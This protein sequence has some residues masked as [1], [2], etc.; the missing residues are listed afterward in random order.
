[1]LHSGLK[2]APQRVRISQPESCSNSIYYAC[3]SNSDVTGIA[4]S[5]LLPGIHVRRALQPT[6]KLRALVREPHG[7]TGLKKSGKCI[8]K[9]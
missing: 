9:T 6:G 7:G 2:N 1:L 4:Q 3:D 8:Q 5:S